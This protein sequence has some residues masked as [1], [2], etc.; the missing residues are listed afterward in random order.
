MQ[1][2]KLTNKQQEI[3]LLTP[4]FR[5]LTTNQI[6]QFLNH[7]NKK[8]INTWLKNLR[9]NDFLEWDFDPKEFREKNKPAAYHIG[10]NG[11]RFVKTK[12]VPSQ[13]IQKLYRDNKR[14]DDFIYR[15]LLLTNIG[16]ELRAKS[17]RDA[18]YS[19]TTNTDLDYQDSIFNFLKDLS[20]QL[21]F[22]KKQK[23]KKYYRLLEIFDPILPQRAIKRRIRQYFEFLLSGEWEDNISKTLPTVL[24]ICPSLSILISLKRFTKRL[25][26]DEN[27]ENLDI[28]F[29][30]VNEVKKYGVIAEVWEGI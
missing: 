11:I 6:Q 20:P 17:N 2:P 8:T 16:L 29:A 28:S 30:T 12:G 24:F 14:G 25:L 1:L 13:I 7:K 15:C 22:I 10:I 23:G 21:V 27:A 18:A 3:I 26:E 4:K 9:D 5:F 19:V